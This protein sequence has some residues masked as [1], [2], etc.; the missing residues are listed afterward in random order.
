MLSQIL[1][2]LKPKR[3]TG[4]KFI[5]NKKCPTTHHSPFSLSSGA[6]FWQ[7]HSVVQ[8]EKLEL[9]PQHT[10]EA[11]NNRHHMSHCMGAAAHNLPE[12]LLVHCKLKVLHT[13]ADQLL[14]HNWTVRLAGNWNRFEHTQTEQAAAENGDNQA[15]Q[16]QA[17][18]SLPGHWGTVGFVHKLVDW[19][20]PSEPVVVHSW[21]YSQTGLVVDSQNQFGKLGASHTLA[22]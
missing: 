1:Q 3:L 21:W 20:V 11:V 19:L 2:I 18:H 8:A 12:S 7:P 16:E 13:L 9:H 10:L 15:A 6:M 22:D 5:S 17:G 14:F 4:N